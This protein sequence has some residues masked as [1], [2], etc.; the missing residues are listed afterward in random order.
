MGAPLT[1]LQT[2]KSIPEI[3]SHYADIGNND[4]EPRAHRPEISFKEPNVFQRTISVAGVG[5][6]QKIKLLLYGSKGLVLPY[7]AKASNLTV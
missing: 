7:L 6:Q 5:K 1:F 3:E 2:V 4:P